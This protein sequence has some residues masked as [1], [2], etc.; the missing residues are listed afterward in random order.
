MVVTTSTIAHYLHPCNFWP[1]ISII[2]LVGTL[3]TKLTRFYMRWEMASGRSRV[4]ADKSGVI[5]SF[6]GFA[7]VRIMTYI[8]ANY[9]HTH[10]TINPQDI[11]STKQRFIFH[12]LYAPGTLPIRER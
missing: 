5:C 10:F 8:S 11:F 1:Y 2:R 9:S 3:L 7:S 6:S 12:V 4:F